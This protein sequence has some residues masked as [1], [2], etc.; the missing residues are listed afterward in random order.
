MT[1]RPWLDPCGRKVDWIRS[2]YD[3]DMV[4]EV[5][6]D[7]VR[8][9]WYFPDDAQPFMPPGNVFVS[10]NWVSRE[11]V[12]GEI[13]EQPGTRPWSN[14]KNEKLY[15]VQTVDGCGTDAAFLGG[16]SGGQTTGPWTGN[17]LG[18]CSLVPSCCG[19][20]DIPMSLGLTIVDVTGFCGCVAG[21][22]SLTW[23]PYFMGGFVATPG[24]W[25]KPISLCGS[26]VTLAVYCNP[27]IPGYVVGIPDAPGGSTGGLMSPA[28]ALP[29]ST[30]N[31][32]LT[33]AGLAGC[34][35]LTDWTVF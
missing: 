22:Y 8:V 32:D 14:G 3:V 24:A 28:C 19:G 10:D 15:P 34:I 29:W 33:F 31:I 30:I 1:D 17:V 6:A 18:C 7:P 5:G 23:D 16:L 26:V 20:D 4:F 2:A 9:R 35:G 13:G 12:A 25:T 11:S 21:T 27:G